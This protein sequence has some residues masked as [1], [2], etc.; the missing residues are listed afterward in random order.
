M[1]Q[2]NPVRFAVMATV[3]GWMALSVDAQSPLPLPNAYHIDETF[4][5]QIPPD[6]QVFGAVSA[7]KIGPDNNLYVF[8]RCGATTCTGHDNVAPITVYTQQG[9][10]LRTTGAGMFVWPHGLAVMPDLSMWLT[11]AVSGTGVDK[12]NPGKGH[13]VFH[14]DKNGKVLVAIGS[15]GSCKP[16]SRRDG[17]LI[18][19]CEAPE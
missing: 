4:K 2:R 11:D 13:Q 19:A 12:N 15:L 7:V 17:P 18:V 14:V 5:L 9:K 16:S 6:S 10:L 1:F 8:R 3:F